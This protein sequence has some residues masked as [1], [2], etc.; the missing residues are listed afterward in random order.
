MFQ[1]LLLA[2]VRGGNGKILII[3]LALAVAVF[4]FRKFS[5][6]EN[7]VID[8]DELVEKIGAMGKMEFTRF[9]VTDVIKS[10][11]FREW[12]PDSKV[13]FE[14]VGEAAGCIDLSKVKASDVKRSGDSI[15]ISLPKP[16]ICSVKVNREKSKVYDAVSMRLKENSKPV[17]E[18]V[19]MIAEEELNKE[20][21]EM[22]II[23]ETAK[24][25][26]RVLRPLLEKMAGRKV[27]LKVKKRVVN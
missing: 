20:A 22:G 26:N 23:E 8:H 15:I 25:A 19:I 1:K 17:P 13:Q 11:V 18:E 6:K 12:W 3:I 16:E 7:V 4:I 14:A 10:P 21:L 5:T 27:G 24:N 2:L 9:T